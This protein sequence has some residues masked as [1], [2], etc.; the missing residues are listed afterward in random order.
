M[1]SF[2]YETVYLYE[3]IYVFTIS[4]LTGTDTMSSRLTRTKVKKL[5]QN[6]DAA[7]APCPPLLPATADCR[8]GVLDRTKRNQK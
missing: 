5:K 3:L 2:P 8:I 4:S 7:P 1:N 6:G